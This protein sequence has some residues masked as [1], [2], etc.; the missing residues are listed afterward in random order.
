MA[1]K[2]C[3]KCGHG[4]ASMSQGVAVNFCGKCGNSLNSLAAFGVNSNPKKKKEAPPARRSRW[5]KEE[6]DDF[7]DEYE[8]EQEET[9]TQEEAVA[10][11]R[12]SMSLDT[13]DLQG[14]MKAG[15]IVGMGG[16]GF[17]RPKG[18]GGYDDKKFRSDSQT[19]KGNPDIIGGNG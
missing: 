6:E 5:A 17:D 9:I 12:A 3:S 18:K 14:P 11:L 15:D 19:S 16:T 1:T 4:N 13:S 7:E 10:S 2:Y 8:D